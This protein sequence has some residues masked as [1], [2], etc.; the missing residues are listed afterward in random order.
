MSELRAF[1]KATSVPWAILP[2]SLQQIFEIAAREHIPDF[3]AVAAKR[4]RRLDGAEGVQ[5]REGGV[6]VIPITGPIFRYADFFTEVS[7]GAT[8]SSLAR[9]F[10]AA[11]NDPNVTAILLNIDSPGGEVAGINEFSQMVFDARGKKPIVSYVDGLGASAAYWIASATDEIIADRTAMLGSIGVVAAVPNPAA[12]TARDI[13]F[14][15]SQSPKKRPNP[16]TESGKAQIQDL[17]DDLAG[18]FVST[19]ARN[20][21]VSEK[22]VL[23]DFGQGA[24]L[25]G[26]KAVSAGLADRLG[27]F[28]ELVAELA[29]AKWRDKRKKKMAAESEID[30]AQGDEMQIADNL[31]KVRQRILAALD[32]GE[33]ESKPTVQDQIDEIV[34]EDMAADNAMVEA[35]EAENQKLR[36]EAAEAK[37]AQVRADA[38]SFTDAQIAAGKVFPAERES[39]IEA[40]VQAAADDLVNPLSDSSRVEKVR[41][42]VEARPS[43]KLTQEMVIGPDHRVLKSDENNQTE[44]SDERRRELLA[45]TPTGKA[46]L[47]AV[48]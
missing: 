8:V 15:S 40:L 6:A 31:K 24:V 39:L 18:V 14:V 33:E 25:V 5:I 29:S 30:A 43:H 2:E 4:A 42:Q 19:M 45:K 1:T 44:M 3:E 7:G 21:S 41:A 11:L 27:S 46:A 38:E 23:N 17:V 20:R 28:E 35:L 9:D 34:A 47:K 12:R 22:K 13:E 36:K 32:G 48:K 37:A 16:N 26:A 10:N